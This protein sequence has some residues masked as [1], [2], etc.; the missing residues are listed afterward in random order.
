MFSQNNIYVNYYCVII[1]LV[2]KT[3]LII[4]FMLSLLKNGFS[5]QLNTRIR[6]QT[7]NCVGI[8]TFIYASRLLL[9]KNYHFLILY[10]Y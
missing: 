10:L 8:S 4:V 3:M 1:Y 2:N 6:S 9:T 5:E 7:N